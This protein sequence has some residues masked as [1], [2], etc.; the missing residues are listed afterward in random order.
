MDITAILNELARLRGRFPRAAVEAAIAQQTTITPELLRILEE[1]INRADMFAQDGEYMAHFYALY[2]LAQFR[3]ARAYPLVVRL[4]L[5]PSKLLDDLCGDFITETLGRVL[6]SVCGG[7]LAGIQQVIE[8]ADADE[9]ARSA[10]LDA[11]VTLVAAGVKSREEIVALLGSF[12]RGGIER[13]ESAVWS[14]LVNATCDLWPGDLLDDIELAFQ[15]GLIE[16]LSV[17]RE[18]VQFAF[19]RGL[20]GQLA[21]TARSRHHQPID[22]T[23]RDFGGWACFQPQKARRDALTTKGD[24]STTQQPP[25]NYAPLMKDTPKTGRNDPCP[26]GSGR[27][28]KKCCLG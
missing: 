23:V 19:D 18:D 3:E 7:D 22:D 14:G 21:A 2:L 20:E 12:Y 9:W 11:L 5:L 1:T 15:D 10:A 8:S 25:L 17:T 4:A 27:K 26:C 6:A 24:P 13:H 28:Y 16:R